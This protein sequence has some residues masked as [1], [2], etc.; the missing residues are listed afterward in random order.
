MKTPVVVVS[1]V[2]IVLGGAGLYYFLAQRAENVY[3]ERARGSFA[4]GNYDRAAELAFE[5][6]ARAGTPRRDA[7]AVYLA[8]ESLRKKGRYREARDL[9]LSYLREGKRTDPAWS[10]RIVAALAGTLRE[11]GE[12]R[13]IVETLLKSK[14]VEAEGDRNLKDAVYAELGY[15]YME[16]KRMQDAVRCFQES[17]SDEARVGIAEAY[18]RA[19][20]APAAVRSYADFVRFCPGSSQHD[21]ARKKLYETAL[22]AAKDLAL[23]QISKANE[24]LSAIR[25]VN[26]AHCTNAVALLDAALE[27]SWEPVETERLLW[28]KAQAQWAGGDHEGSRGTCSRVLELESPDA[29]YDANARWLA[30]LNYFYEERFPDALAMFYECTKSFPGTAAAEKSAQYAKACERQIQ[31]V[32]ESYAD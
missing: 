24:S 21:Q 1:I 8:G 13:D 25:Q 15:L 9:F 12:S 17:A 3:L 11:G 5:Y 7:E 30:G 18:L 26:R 6:R 16:E 19:G 20:D 28:W 31:I 10:T 4:S 14:L 27:F 22:A 23:P 29:T 32:P 2:L